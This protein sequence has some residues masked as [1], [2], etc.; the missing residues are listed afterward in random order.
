MIREEVL[1]F[2]NKPVAMW[3]D[4]D[5]TSPPDDYGYIVAEKGELAVVVG[6]TTARLNCSCKAA[7]IGTIRYDELYYIEE[8]KLPF[9]LTLDK[10]IKKFCNRP[11]TSSRYNLIV[12]Q[13]EAKT[14][15]D[16]QYNTRCQICGS[17]AYQGLLSLQCSK[18]CK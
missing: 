8:V 14:Q 10:A 15:V 4:K 16:S 5:K 2:A 9:N 12:P 6:I 11:V 1:K 7:N 3:W 17:P 18:G 13:E